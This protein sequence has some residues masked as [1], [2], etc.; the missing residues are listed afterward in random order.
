MDFS[1]FFAFKIPDDVTTSIN[2]P[3]YPPGKVVFAH[4]FIILC[5]KKLSSLQRLGT[6][7]ADETVWVINLTQGLQTQYIY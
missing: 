7:G 1:F 5:D 2:Y 6:H 3:V 4:W